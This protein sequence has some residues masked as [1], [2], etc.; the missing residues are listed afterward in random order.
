M[1]VKNKGQIKVGPVIYKETFKKNLRG[2]EGQRLFGQVQHLP[3][4]IELDASLAGVELLLT[5]WHEVLHALEDLYGVILSE[6]EVSLLSTGIVQILL[7]NDFMRGNN[8]S[9]RA[10]K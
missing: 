1:G 5:R 6:S 10:E 8:I 3:R 7:D 2:D 9:A 4:E